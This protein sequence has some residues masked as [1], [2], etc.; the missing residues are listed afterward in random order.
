MLITI[1][2]TGRSFLHSCSSHTVWRSQRAANNVIK[3]QQ[4]GVKKQPSG[5]NRTE[6]ARLLSRRHQEWHSVCAKRRHRVRGLL[7]ALSCITSNRSKQPDLRPRSYSHCATTQHQQCVR[8]GEKRLLS[9]AIRL[10]RRAWRPTSPLSLF[11][12]WSFLSMSWS[13]ASCEAKRL[14]LCN[15]CWKINQTKSNH[16]TPGLAKMLSKKMEQ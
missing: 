12:E 14:F 13:R 10:D 5:D 2:V 1:I 8:F 15:V 3:I 4:K 16:A 9:S 11:R 6:T 7:M